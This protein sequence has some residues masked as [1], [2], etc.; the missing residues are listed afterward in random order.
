MTVQEARVWQRFSE[1]SCDEVTFEH[2]LS[3]H[4]LTYG[5]TGEGVQKHHKEKSLV[6]QKTF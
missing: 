1:R 5:N 4:K 3:G 6:S 2:G